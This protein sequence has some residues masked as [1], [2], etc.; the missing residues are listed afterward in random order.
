MSAPMSPERLDEIR[1]RVDGIDCYDGDAETLALSLAADVRDLLAV[2]DAVL[3]PHSHEVAYA[4]DTY[5]D[6]DLPEGYERHYCN[7]DGEDWPCAFVVA[8]TGAGGGS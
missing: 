3:V 7:E 6:T 1:E 5:S 2:L 4:D 8:V